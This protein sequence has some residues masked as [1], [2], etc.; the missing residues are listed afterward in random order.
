MFIRKM[1]LSVLL[2]LLVLPIYSTT[3][4]CSGGG[5]GTPTPEPAPLGN[6]AEGGACTA[7]ADCVSGLFC[8]NAVCG[9]AP[10]DGGSSAGG[11]SAGGGTGGGGGGTEVKDTDGDGVADTTDNCVDAVNA[12]QADMDADAK[13]D[14][15]DDSDGDAL[16]DASD[17][18]S[19]IANADQADMD[20]DAKGDECDDDKDGDGVANATDNCPVKSNPAQDDMDKDGVGTMCETSDGSAPVIVMGPQSQYKCPSKESADFYPEFV[21]STTMKVGFT[22]DP[23]VNTFECTLDGQIVDCSSKVF[24]K[25]DLGDGAH[26]FYVTAVDNEEDVGQNGCEW[27]VDKTP[28]NTNFNA[29]VAQKWRGVDLAA[30]TEVSDTDVD[31]NF[32]K[33]VAAYTYKNDAVFIDDYFMSLNKFAPVLY[34]GVAYDIWVYAYDKALNKSEPVKVS[35]SA[36]PNWASNNVGELGSEQT[37]MPNINGILENKNDVIGLIYGIGTYPYLGI[38]SDTPP[39]EPGVVST[40]EGVISAPIAEPSSRFAMAM[41]DNGDIHLAYITKKNANYVVE[42]VYNDGP[43]TWAYED[44]SESTDVMSNPAIALHGNDVWIAFDN[45][46]SK[47]LVVSRKTAEG[48]PFFALAGSMTLPT[49]PSLVIKGDVIYVTYR[50]TTNGLSTKLRLGYCTTYAECLSLSKWTKLTVDDGDGATDNGGSAFKNVGFSNKLAFDGAGIP[51]ITYFGADDMAVLYTQNS[52]ADSSTWSSGWSFIT[53]NSEDQPSNGYIAM[54]LDPSGTAH[55]A[56][57]CSGGDSCQE[58][59]LLYVPI[60]SP[61]GSI[62]SSIARDFKVE[63]GQVDLVQGDMAIFA[64]DNG[65][66]WICFSDTIAN[67]IKCAIDWK[68]IQ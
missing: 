44:V 27:V 31:V 7:D 48:W 2:V 28:P 45:E 17:N 67:K 51:K 36:A 50:D 42:H 8:L 11:S 65:S 41:A 61:T 19:A 13:G 43:N 22:I 25:D 63:S 40:A 16:V 4:G 35:Y 23:D 12:D 58:D 6:V 21:S 60:V 37:K 10:A 46:A 20:A 24:S 30:G 57:Y 3:I 64:P 68:W 54:G 34:N 9:K 39:L 5:S 29:A 18:C 52:S 47:R 14:A 53:V 38:F 32:A 62:S 49:K 15:C 66:T 26:K 56:W 33:Y 59:K 55:V 1:I